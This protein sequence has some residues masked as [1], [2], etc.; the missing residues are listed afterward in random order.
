MQDLGL[1]RM[2]DVFGL[3]PVEYPTTRVM[4]APLEDRARDIIAAYAD[5]K[6][7]AVFASIGGSDQ[8]KLIKYLEPD[9]FVSNP[10]PFFWI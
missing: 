9:I 2:R 8:I 5:N 1:K 10:K 7:K 4:N 3:V 6:N